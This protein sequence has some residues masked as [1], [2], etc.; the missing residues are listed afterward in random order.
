MSFKVC[1]LLFSNYSKI[2]HLY[3]ICLVILNQNIPFPSA[4]NW[5]EEVLIFP[6]LHLKLHTWYI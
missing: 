1:G 5:E 3:S 4:V 6:H 2:D